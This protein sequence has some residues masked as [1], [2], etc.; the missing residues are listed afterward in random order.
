MATMTKK[1]TAVDTKGATA[2][3]SKKAPPR[4]LVQRHE[5]VFAVV[6]RA[7][8]NEGSYELLTCACGRKDWRPVTADE[9]AEEQIIDV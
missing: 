8:G 3:K 5:H 6:A 9:A 4:T 1:K 7:Q 2:K